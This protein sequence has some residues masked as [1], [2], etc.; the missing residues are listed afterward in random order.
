MSKHENETLNQRQNATS[1][2]SAAMRLDPATERELYQLYRTYFRVAESEHG[3]DSLWRTLDSTLPGP[4][5]SEELAAAALA[6][7]RQDLYLPDYN[8][9]ALIR[10]RGSRG[11]AWFWTRWSY[12]ESRHLLGMH[13]WLIARE[14]ATQEELDQLN[15]DLLATERWTPASDDAIYLFIDA[16]LWELSEIERANALLAQAHEDE[17]LILLLEGILADERAQ[18]DYLTDALRIIQRN[19]PD[20]VAAA[21]SLAATEY[22]TP[23]MAE[24][25][26][27]YLD[28]APETR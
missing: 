12:E 2:R 7:Y 5:P 16:L 15:D 25:L 4:K 21:I 8:T 14:V 27:A 28:G 13:E 26:S 20:R 9:A 6:G 3:R 23:A 10:L 18:R 1:E 11:R 17:A 19:Y 22:E 24:Q